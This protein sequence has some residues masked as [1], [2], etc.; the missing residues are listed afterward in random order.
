MRIAHIAP[1]YA[2]VIGCIKGITNVLELHD[3]RSNL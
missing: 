1:S 3:V 2:S